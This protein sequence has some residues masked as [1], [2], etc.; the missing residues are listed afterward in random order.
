MKKTAFKQPRSF[1]IL[2]LAAVI[3]AIGLISFWGIAYVNGRQKLA[4]TQQQAAATVKDQV[5]V[6]DIHPIIDTASLSNAA[7]QLAAVD[8]EVS[9]D[10]CLQSLLADVDSITKQ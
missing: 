9:T 1:L 10:T 4:S 8:T 2:E 7:D 6:E 3:V 5:T